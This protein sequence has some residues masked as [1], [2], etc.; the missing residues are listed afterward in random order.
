VSWNEMPVEELPP[1]IVE[2]A[3]ALGAQDA[4]CTLVESNTKQIRFANSSITAS[5]SWNSRT[6]GV[7]LAREGRVVATEINDF[8]TV[9]QS[10]EDLVKMSRV[11]EPSQNY[12]GIAG[13]EFQ[14]RQVKADGS[15]PGLL[16]ELYDYVDA[17]ISSARDAGAKRVAGVLYSSHGALHLASSGGPAGSYDTADIEI[18]VRAMA[19]NEGSGHAVQSVTE[20]SG[21][22]PGEVGREAGRR[23]SDS[24]N[25]KLGK[26]GRFEVLFS[27]MTFAN[28][29]ERVAN[30]CSAGLVD[31]G[32]SFLKDKVGQQVAGESVSLVDDGTRPEAFSAPPF[33]SEGAPTGRTTL[34]EEGVLKGYLHNTSTARQY[35]T[36]TTGNAGLVFPHSWT[37]YLQPGER[38]FG[39]LVG[40]VENG[41]YITNTWYTRFQNYQTGDFSTIPRDAIFKIEKGEIVGSVK[42]IRISENMLNILKNVTALGN[43]PSQ[44]HWWEV[45]IPTVTPHV[46]VRDVNVTRSTQ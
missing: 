38:S 10:L 1:R 44:I 27:P 20:L 42:D 43:D 18:S 41:Y 40:G 46:L 16:E 3:L 34:I 15:I 28:I 45:G 4:I 30:S 24:R 12:L 32:L 6:A 26:E 29:L 25:P 5:K 11:M 7:F 17:A 8:T 19:E 14:Y 2:K 33:D 9:D 23:A 22:E 36:E 39:E 13:G 35:K 21:F 31:A 37:T